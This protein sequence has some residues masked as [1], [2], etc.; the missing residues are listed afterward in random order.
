MKIEPSRDV[1][2]KIKR[3]VRDLKTCC[4]VRTLEQSVGRLDSLFLRKYVLDEGAERLCGRRVDSKFNDESLELGHC[5]RILHDV[6][7]QLHHR[8]LG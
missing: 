8:R 5:D 1:R 6:R 3:R 4:A 2:A 7:E